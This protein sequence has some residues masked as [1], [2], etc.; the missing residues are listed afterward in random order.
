KLLSYT[1]DDYKFEST[2]P[3]LK[4]LGRVKN[5]FE[6]VCGKARKTVLHKGLIFLKNQELYRIIIGSSNMTQSALQR[7]R[8]GIRKLYL[9]SR[10][11][12]RFM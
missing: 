8:S 10:E 11:N 4:T 9:P 12:I 5:T 6:D 1:I 2:A 3:A 7:I